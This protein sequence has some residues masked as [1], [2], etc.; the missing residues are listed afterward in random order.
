MRLDDMGFLIISEGGDGLGLAIRLQNEGHKTSMWIRDPISDQRGEGLVQKG[1]VPELNST[2]I[3]DCTGAG[4][5][6]DSYRS[7]E[8]RTFGG[9][10]IADKL[11]SDRKLATEVF[12]E[13]KIPQPNS[14]NFTNW[15]E[16]EEY[17]NNYEGESKLVFKPEGKFSG[18]LPSYVP[19]NNDELLS[20][21]EHFKGIIGSEEPEFVLQEFIE[22][23]CIS[24]EIWCAK[25]QP[26]WPT[27]HTLERK[28]F[29]N[30]DIGPSGGCTGNV[31]WRCDDM[32]CPL[33]ANLLKL[34]PFLK[35]HEWTGPIDINTVVS[36]EGSIYALEFTPRMGYDAFPTF[37]SGLFEGDFGGFINDSCRGDSRDQPLR[38]GFA[39]GIRVSLP[40][41]P[42]EDFHSKSGIEIRGLRESDVSGM[43]P[44][45]YP[46]EVSSQKD[47]YV[48]SGG[49]GA[50]GVCV[51][52][53]KDVETAFDEAYSMVK[54]LKIPDMQYR[55]D[56]AHVFKKDLYMLRRAFNKTFARV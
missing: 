40:P 9:S 17:I 54:K 46:Y 28:Q 34:E 7:S 49:W 3:A 37:L 5:L 55:T 36:N 1:E 45:F 24:S 41:W 51:G 42:S 32:S 35:E 29:M 27:N 53:G 12:N 47:T 11:E 10:Q 30:G 43:A 8:I 21:F 6:L 50:V 19:N 25:G 56:F 23:T 14:Q 15:E 13:C 38:E 44:S 20:M 26:I 18:V 16:A 33:C 31:V 22:G 39:A 2:I 48:T 4:A 52:Y